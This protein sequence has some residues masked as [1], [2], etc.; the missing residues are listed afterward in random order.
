ME[1]H[2]AGFGII[3]ERVEMKEI[4]SCENPSVKQLI[5]LKK[6]KNREQAGRYIIEGP[7][8]VMEA[9]KNQIIPEVVF[10]RTSA[11]QENPKEQGKNE[12][13]GLYQML[14]GLPQGKPRM[15]LLSDTVFDKAAQ[16]ETP[17]GVMAVVPKRERV[18]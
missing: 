5:A 14:C 2:P 17:Q 11:L 4:I 18:F 7:N 16:T 12:Y 10:F 13:I 3:K 8:L 9:V 6:K 1:K 15:V